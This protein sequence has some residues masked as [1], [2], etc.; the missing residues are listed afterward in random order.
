MVPQVELFFVHF[1]GE[2]KTPKGHFEINSP[3]QPGPLYLF[4]YPLYAR[5]GHLTNSLGTKQQETCLHTL[6]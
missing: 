1:L 4:K 6:D 5:D 3:L 2:L